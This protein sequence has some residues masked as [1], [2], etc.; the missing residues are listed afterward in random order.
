MSTPVIYCGPEGLEANVLRRYLGAL[1]FKVQIVPYG[2]GLLSA[3]SAHPD[4]ITVMQSVGG[5]QDL[6]E[7]I[8]EM[9]ECAGRAHLT[10]LILDDHLKLPRERGD[11][12]LIP[13]P[14][15]LSRVIQRIQDYARGAN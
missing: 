2:D 4:A 5:E 6:P 12:E 8:H 10:V 13:G 9:R 11:V 7:L 3:I 1:G 15:R 14:M